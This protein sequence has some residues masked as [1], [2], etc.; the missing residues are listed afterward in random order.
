MRQKILIKN[1]RKWWRPDKE[2]SIQVINNGGWHF[3]NFFS[4]KSNFKI[5][6]KMVFSPYSLFY[7]KEKWTRLLGG[8][9]RGMGIIDN[10]GEMGGGEAELWFS[11]AREGRKG[12]SCEKRGISV[13]G[14]LAFSGMSLCAVRISDSGTKRWT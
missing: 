2:K 8:A 9:T 3:N 10:Q 1:L 11:S 14:R 5:N 12:D 13:S 6:L 7:K 4:P